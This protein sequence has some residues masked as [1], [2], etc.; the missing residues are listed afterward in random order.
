GGLYTSWL[1]AADVFVRVACPAY[2]LRHVMLRPIRG[3]MD[4]AEA[5]AAGDLDRR[6]PTGG[7]REMAHLADS[8][9]RMTDRLLEERAHLVRVERMASVGRLAAGIAHEIGKPL[10]AVN[11][12]AHLLH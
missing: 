11:G 2:Q 3:A 5:I 9:N 7:T 10:G 6:L 8:V 1:V 4:A 12:C